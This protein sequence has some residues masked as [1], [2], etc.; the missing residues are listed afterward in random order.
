[1]LKYVQG[2]S[3]AEIGEIMREG[4]REPSRR[5]CTGPFWRFAPNWPALSDP[6]LARNDQKGSLL[7]PMGEHQAMSLTNR[8]AAA[9]GATDAHQAALMPL[10]RTAKRVKRSLTPCSHPSPFRPRWRA[11]CCM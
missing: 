6:P 5:C 7:P 8:P 9:G 11:S 1:M 3:N 10:L 4:A 2:M